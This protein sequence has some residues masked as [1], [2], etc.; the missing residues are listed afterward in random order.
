MP[1]LDPFTR[2][3]VKESLIAI[4]DEMFIA[5]QRTSM[6]PIIYEVL[7][8]ATGLLNADGDLITQGNG[9]AGFLGTLTFVTKSVMAKFGGDLALGDVVIT[10]DPYDGGG[11]HLSDVTLVKPIFVAEDLVAFAAN[12]A[13][14][15]E[16]GGSAPGSWTTDARD[17]WQEGLQFPCI[18]LYERG[19]IDRKLVEMIRANVRTP[20][21]SI[22]DMSAQVASLNI[23]E[24]R[25]MALCDR[26]GVATVCAA[27][28]TLLDH[29][30]A[31]TR[32]QLA[33]IP[34]GVYEAVDYIDDDGVG[35]GP[36]EMRVQVTVTDERFICDFTG[37]HP[38]VPGP[39][40]SGRSG[41]EAAV[42][43]IFKALTD[44][45]I[46]A[47][48][49]CFRPLTVI[50]PQGTVVTA[51]HPA[52]TSIYWESMDFASDLVWRALAPVLPERLTMGHFL[53]V[54]GTVISGLHPETG[55]L[56]ILVEP[57]AGGWGAGAD[58]DGENALVSMGDG[59]TYVIPVEV[60]ETRYGVLVDQFALS[61]CDGGAGRYRGGRGLVRDY[62]IKA[63]EAYVTGTFGRFKYPPWGMNG[64][65][66]GSPNYM[67]MIHADGTTRVF[68]KVAQYK[69]RRGEVVRLVTGTGGGY[70]DPRDRS[71]EAVA[72]D[73]RNGYITPEAAVRD[74]GT[75]R[76]ERE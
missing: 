45:Q 13:H 55:E 43:V 35:N 28:T 31:L 25:F 74:Y 27:I 60:C 69:L 53:S 23:A 76:V 65:Q 59:E 63:D 12:K 10:N 24:R 42:R 57:Q 68:G 16:V 72:R 19:A 11:T 48:D 17:V 51:E 5:M 36:F 9:V 66:P 64:G 2:E 20:E 62:R 49:G 14:W 46:P 3:I 18:K 54:C 50:C 47:N 26:Y 70:G 15:T 33:R 58:R 71:A 22:G 8:Y 56:F 44:P 41:L 75:D 29:G 34:N 61:I 30:E 73:A 1:G 21:M 67:E 7:D 40:N 38:Q 52:P 37:C 39:I 32:Q 6:S 4:G